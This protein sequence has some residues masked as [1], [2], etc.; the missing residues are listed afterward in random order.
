[1]GKGCKLRVIKGA[2]GEF[3]NAGWTGYVWPWCLWF[4][5]IYKFPEELFWLP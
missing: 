4:G 2:T 3:K 1:V 5:G